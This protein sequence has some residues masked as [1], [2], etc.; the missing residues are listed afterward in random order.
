[1]TIDQISASSPRGEHDCA[2]P[3]GGA[4]APLLGAGRGH[5]R[6]FAPG[7]HVF[8]QGAP[9]ESVFCV[10]SGSLK[11]YFTGVDGS[12][13]VVDFRFAGEPLGLEGAAQDRC[14]YSAVALE[15]SDLRWFSRS[16]IVRLLTRH[17]EL[18]AEWIAGCGRDLQ[19]AFA[20]RLAVSQ[21]DPD[22]RLAYFL[23]DI[24]MRRGGPRVRCVDLRLPMTRFDIASYLGVAAETVSRA[25][26]RLKQR[27]LLNVEGRLI[28]IFDIERLLDCARVRDRPGTPTTASVR[29][30][31]AAGDHYVPVCAMG[32]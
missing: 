28:R 32:G 4:H 7:E 24:A 31:M 27:G 26:T 15:H 14:A 8:H 1:M 23:A 21:W 10:Q 3:V 9:F 19:R 17:P 5:R 29:Q 11:S 2:G 30:S 22:R 20:C 13:L 16:E 6:T 18:G 25:F 12:E